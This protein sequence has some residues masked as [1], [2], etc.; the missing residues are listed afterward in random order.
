MGD[1]VSQD[2]LRKNVRMGGTCLSDSLKNIADKRPDLAIFC[3]DGFYGDIDVESW[4][5]PG[6][7]FPQTVFVI[8]NGGSEKHP[9]SERSWQTTVKVPNK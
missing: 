4:L 1:R 2:M 3:T 6:Q 8:E 9:F 7:K 5:K